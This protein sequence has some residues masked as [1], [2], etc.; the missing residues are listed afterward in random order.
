[1]KFSHFKY[2][3]YSQTIRIMPQ[4]YLLMNC[5]SD[6]SRCLDFDHAIDNKILFKVIIELKKGNHG[7]TNK[8]IIERLNDSFNKKQCIS[9]GNYYPQKESKIKN[10]CNSCASDNNILI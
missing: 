4:N 8:N 7:Y 9:C 5:T 3:D 6:L 2:C 10:H 1:M